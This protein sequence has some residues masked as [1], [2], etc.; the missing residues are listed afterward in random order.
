MRNDRV[1]M[2]S[3]LVASTPITIELEDGW[4]V[5]KMEAKS[6]IPT[7]LPGIELTSQV[8]HS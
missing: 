2:N 3:D 4:T 1:T 5:L 6:K 7:P 8:S